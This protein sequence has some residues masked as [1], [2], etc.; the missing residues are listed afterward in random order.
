MTSEPIRVV[1]HLDPN[2][3]LVSVLRNAVHFQALQAGLG[4]ESCAEFAQ[5][6]ED[7]C[8]ETCSQLAEGGGGLD[9]ILDT[10]PDRIE[11]SIHNHGQSVPAV[12]LESFAFSEALAG[13]EG[14]VNGLELLSKVDRVLF[15]SEDGVARTTLV[16]FIKST[17]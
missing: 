2:P 8:R 13:G 11:I 7:V 16:K 6:S 12:G 3:V 1:F 14:K 9:V 17:H 10:F 4:S 15:S 5:A